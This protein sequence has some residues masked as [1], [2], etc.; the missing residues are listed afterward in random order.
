MNFVL[1]ALGK[2]P[3]YLEDC[4]FQIKQTQKKSKI[5]LLLNK[6]SGYKNKN[7]K[8][9]FVEDL[10]KSKEHIFFIKKSKL[11]K[12][13]YRNFFW[14]HSIERLYFIDNF[15]NKTKLTNV[16]HIENDVMVFQPLFNLLPKDTSK[17]HLTM[18]CH[19]RS[20]PGIMF[21]PNHSCMWYLIQNWNH[22]KN[23]MINLGRFCK[24][25]SGVCETFPIMIPDDTF[26]EFTK[27]FIGYIYDAAAIGQYLGGIDPKND[28][29]DT[30]GF[31]TPE[32]VF[33]FNNFKFRWMK[34]P[35]LFLYVPHVVIDDSTVIPIANLHIHCKRLSNF[36]ADNPFE[37]KLIEID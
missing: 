27:N 33:K 18:D 17:I 29:R 4:I 34:D 20:V 14:K 10:K 5:F 26:P 25:N 30:R 8:I 13:S 32:S 6:D 1:V 31:L 35:V 19:E 24:N 11:V 12:D 3:K 22:N 7:C 36:M 9:I 21:I 37:T 16:F 23:D 28:P 2:I 15:L